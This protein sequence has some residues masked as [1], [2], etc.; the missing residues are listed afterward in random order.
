MQNPNQALNSELEQTLNKYEKSLNEFRQ[1][2]ITVSGAEKRI[3]KR[4][5]LVPG[6][7]SLLEIEKCSEEEYAL[8]NHATKAVLGMEAEEL[9]NKVRNTF[10]ENQILKEACFE[11]IEKGANV[12]TQNENGNSFL[13]LISDITLQFIKPYIV[14]L[15]NDYKANIHLQNYQGLTPIQYSNLVLF[16]MQAQINHLFEVYEIEC[17]YNTSG[18]SAFVK[19][20]LLLIDL[21]AKSENCN[22]K[23]TSFEDYLCQNAIET[24]ASKIFQENL[25]KLAQDK[26]LDEYLKICAK[27]NTNDYQDV[28]SLQTKLVFWEK[29]MLNK[30]MKDDVLD[31]AE[32][33]QITCGPNKRY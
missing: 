27:R 15:V 24:N 23:G 31:V 9:L 8:I 22:G 6:T 18:L 4:F 20:G 7:A 3:E 29:R 30:I 26:N 13:H 1:L 2:C 5:K 16:Q 10:E 11:L 32:Q 17:I 28:Y 19:T 14:S 25:G 21:G 33:P 12:N